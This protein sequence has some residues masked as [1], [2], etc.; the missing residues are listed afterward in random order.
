MDP[1]AMRKLIESIMEGQA[2]LHLKAM[3]HHSSISN[4]NNNSKLNRDRKHKHF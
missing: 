1:V 4:N 3:L 2:I